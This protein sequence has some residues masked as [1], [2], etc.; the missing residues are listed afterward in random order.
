MQCYIYQP[1]L[2]LITGGGVGTMIMSKMRNLT[3]STMGWRKGLLIELVYIFVACL[4]V[5]IMT[6][7]RK[8]DK[9]ISQKQVGTSQKQ[10]EMSEK[11][12]EISQKQVEMSEKPVE[13]SQKQVV[14]SEKRVKI[15][16]KQI[17]N[18]EAGVVG[19]ATTT[20]APVGYKTIFRQK[21]LYVII[22]CGF[23]TAH[24]IGTTA[25]FIPGF[26]TKDLDYNDDDASTLILIVGL[27]NIISRLGSAFIGN[28]GVKTRYMSELIVLILGGIMTLILPFCTPYAMLATHAAVTGIASG[29]Y[30]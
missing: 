1:V 5:V 15:S 11:R 3:M 24:A 7:D 2:L 29:K 13:I 6:R 12:V 17:E 23:S 8:S 27:A 30:T 14:I 20:P 22:M 19:P 16:Q 21:I 26:V 18:G 28:Y 4:C 10:V 25:N 9:E